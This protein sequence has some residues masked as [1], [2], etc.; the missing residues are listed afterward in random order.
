VENS[1]NASAKILFETWSFEKHVCNIGKDQPAASLENVGY[2]VPMQKIRKIL[3]QLRNRFLMVLWAV[4]QLFL[5]SRPRPMKILA[6]K[7]N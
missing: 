5:R 6:Q 4:P 2:E 1:F 7:R 3:L